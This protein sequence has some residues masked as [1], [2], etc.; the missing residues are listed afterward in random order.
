MAMDP[1]SII[2]FAFPVLIFMSLMWL[3]LRP[4]LPIF[5]TKRKGITPRRLTP[6]S[7][8]TRG[9]APA[10]PVSVHLTSVAGTSTPDGDPT[11]SAVSRKFTA[12][13]RNFTADSSTK[14]HF[15]TDLE[16]QRIKAYREYDSK[17]RVKPDP[18][19]TPYDT[20]SFEEEAW[21]I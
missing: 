18:A 13:S 6:I 3:L 15:V 1:G 9:A 2:L 7:A 11:T 21:Q 8:P 4:T 12:D 16:K 10:T 17:D 19:A 5:P 14:E 20:I